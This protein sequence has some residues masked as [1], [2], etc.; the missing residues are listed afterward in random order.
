MLETTLKNSEEDPVVRHEAA[1]ALAAIGDF[2]VIPL[3]E[4]YAKDPVVEVSETCRLGADGLIY[5]RDNERFGVSKANSVDPAPAEE[6]Q[7]VEALQK[8]LLD[9]NLPL[10]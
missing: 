8:T 10:F 6:T 3:L 4:E 5:Q 2:S 1:E 9:T 7:D